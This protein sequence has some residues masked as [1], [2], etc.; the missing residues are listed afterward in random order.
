MARFPGD[1]VAWAVL[2][3]LVAFVSPVFAE[4]PRPVTSQGAAFVHLQPFDQGAVRLSF[5]VTSLAALPLEGEAIPIPLSL[6]RVAG[7]EM[8]RQR[9]LGFGTLPPGRYS[10]LALTV[11]GGRLQREEGLA[12]L[13]SP[14]GP[15]AISSTLLAGIFYPGYYAE[16]RELEPVA[17][18]GYSIH[19]YE[20]P[21]EAG[22]STVQA[23]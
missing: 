10:G 15:V 19:I 23:E 4:L 3:I 11:R 13:V 9:R 8:D 1:A 17:Q 18:I 16:L 12:D 7:A 5:E 21:A 6:T 2:F 22:A 14:P 20:I